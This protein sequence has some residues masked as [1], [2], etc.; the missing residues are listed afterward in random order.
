MPARPR[1]TNLV[2]LTCARDVSATEFVDVTMDDITSIDELRTI[3]R[4]PARPAL[5]KEHPSITEHDRAFIA[6][7]PFVI[8]STADADGRCDASPKGGPPGF[9]SVLDD[10]TVVVPDLS[11]N[12]RLD[13]MQNVIGNGRVALLFLI[14]GI[15]E[16]LRVN[17]RARLTTDDDVLRAAAVGDVV[18]RVA[19][20]V[21][22]EEAFIHCAQALRRGAVWKPERWP[23]TTDMPSVACML[24]DQVAPDVEVAV[25][26]AALAD[27]RHLWEAG[28]GR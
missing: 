13:S 26:E 11:G 6:H 18:P 23:D 19:I 25:I 4:Q 24:R 8:L 10:G 9:V 17:G 15:E 2:A 1:T 3:Y 22:V 5:A 12:N 28:G 27:E 7:S 14:P 16:T 21:A 20:A